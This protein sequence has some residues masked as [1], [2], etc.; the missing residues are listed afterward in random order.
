M[1]LVGFD[2]NTDREKIVLPEFGREIQKMV[3]HAKT[4]PTKEERQACAET[5]VEVMAFMHPQLHANPEYERKLWDNLAIM[6]NFELD[7]DYPYDISAAQNISEK[8]Q[9][10][11][12]PKNFIPVR[13][14]GKIIFDLFHILEEMPDGPEYDALVQSTASHMQRALIQWGHGT[15][16]VEKIAS[17]LAYFTHGRVQIDPNDIILYRENPIQAAMRKKKK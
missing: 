7:I 11:E 14:Y 3:D 15:A 2:Y 12:I 9:P 4:L 5:I 16:D 17:D 13:H 6:S 8:P 10:L 1:D